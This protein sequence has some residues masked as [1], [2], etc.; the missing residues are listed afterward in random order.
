MGIRTCI[1]RM[2]QLRR[3]LRVTF[4]ALR[5]RNYTKTGRPLP[6]GKITEHFPN[7]RLD[8][9]RLFGIC[10]EPNKDLMD[11]VL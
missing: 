3:Q 5:H 2:R 9:R 6:V 11:E 10:M 1:L 7:F 4:A 8:G